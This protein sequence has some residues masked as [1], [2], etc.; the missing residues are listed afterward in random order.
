LHCPFVRQ[1]AFPLK[2]IFSGVLWPKGK[3]RP[4][5]SFVARFLMP[6]IAIEFR[7]ATDAQAGIA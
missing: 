3:G 4:T 6:V 2:S 1:N 5:D 7:S